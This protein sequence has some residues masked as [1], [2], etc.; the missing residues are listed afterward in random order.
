[1]TND[2]AEDS[3][4]R[5]FPSLVL[6]SSEFRKGREADWLK[7]E[8]LVTLVD[9]KGLS[10]LSADDVQRLPLLYRSVIS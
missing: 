10:A 9:T 1:M 7:M 5:L 4:Q 6:R 3:G 8:E 2:S